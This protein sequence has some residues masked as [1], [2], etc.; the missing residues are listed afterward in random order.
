MRKCRH[1][2]IPWLALGLFALL[3]SLPA[4]RAAAD[5]ASPY[6]VDI[7]SPGGDELTLI[8]NE[9]QAAHIGWVHVA[10]N[11]PWVEGSR[12]SFD[13][14]L[15]DA[16]VSAANA[17]GVQILATILYTPQWATSGPAQTGVPDTA[18]WADFCGQAAR[19]YRGAINYWGLWNEP[20]LAEFWAGS[21]QQYI[22]GVLKP[23]ADAIHA[24]N[25]NAKVGGP[26]LAHLSSTGWFDWLDDVINQAGDHLD[27]VTH[28]VYAADNNGVTSK[29]N[30]STI[31]G[32]TPQLW[33]ISPP[34]VQEVLHHAG[35]WGKPFWLTETGWQSSAVGETPQAAYYSDVLGDWYTGKADQGWLTKIFFYEIKDGTAPGSPSWGILR[36][37]G[38]EKPAYGA[39]K[40]FIAG[41]Q[42]QPSDDAHAVSSNLPG[43]METGQTIT[44][45]LT[46]RNN[47]TTTWTAGGNY[48][49]GAV[50]DSDP[51]AAPRLLLA[52]G[53]AIAPG[54]EKT[55]AFA[56]QAPAAAG[57][58][59]TQWRMLREGVD[60]FGDVAS[61]QVTVT[62][63][64]PPA[65]RTLAL[66]GSRFSV[67]VSWHDVQ[68]GNA[69]F[70]RA[71]PASD[72]T[73]T[74][75]FFDSSNVELVVKA[76]DG[77]SL[78]HHFWF[79]Y[80]ALSDVEYWITV[81]DNVRGAVQTYYNPPGNLCGRGDTSAFAAG[82]SKSS[83]PGAALA[84]LDGDPAAGST[85][86]G[87]WN[88]A[89][90]PGGAAADPETPA[91]AAPARAGEA[92]AASSAGSCVA[93]G[94]DLCLLANR[95]R[96]S[97]TW[98][99]P[100]GQ[101]GTGQ[102]APMSDQTGSFWFF[103][104][105]NLELV[106]KVLDGRAL[107]GKFWVFYAALSDVDYTIT[108]TDTVTGS[109][110]EY[111]NKQGNF[112]GLGDTSALD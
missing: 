108:V 4:G 76:L 92:P 47:G 52:P 54:Q 112:C 62:A 98:Q 55:F 50:S 43:T 111:H 100:S 95:F 85:A 35:W 14:S 41:N 101:S 80:G 77:R 84:G 44:V 64:P 27:F 24:G 65:Q 38:S 33:S 93:D 40:A 36:P 68:N 20:N 97:V 72:A 42:P 96:V 26:A 5:E 2:P 61:R 10:V 106:V 82:R 59:L 83:A 88:A 63:A 60:W 75:W 69:G 19:R 87:R 104:P 99:L 70:G 71:V 81:K 102:A 6:G 16:I 3:F 74:F 18:A 107:T 109:S 12:G 66:L 48:K 91:A 78:N 28:H 21:R 39:Y 9:V 46:F 73:G 58:Y 49:L 89:P 94:Q 56:F 32:G 53:D 1:T 110:K 13:W 105:T 23:G 86:G 90:F 79:F 34:S 45:Q 22:D 17:H 11:W 29:L 30:D 15:Y 8:M 25:P 37:D 57:T 51:L 103:D 7:H 31:F 67:G